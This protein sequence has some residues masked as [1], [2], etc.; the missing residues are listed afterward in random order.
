MTKEP[1]EKRRPGPEPERLKI[2]G[3]WEDV[4]RN[5]LQ[6]GKR[7]RRKEQ[8]SDEEKAGHDES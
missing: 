3:D 5:V 4:L 2:E 7:R 8:E 6:K 1:E